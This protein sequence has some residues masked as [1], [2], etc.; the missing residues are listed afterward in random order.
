MKQIQNMGVIELSSGVDAVYASSRANASTDFYKGLLEIKTALQNEILDV[1]QFNLGESSFHVGPT[2][3]GKYP[4]Y[5]ESK[6]GRI[7]FTQSAHLPGVRLQ[8]RSEFLHSVGPDKALSWFSRILNDADVLTDWKLSRLDLYV[9]I[10]GWTPQLQDFE[11]FITRA[12]AKTMYKDQGVITGFGFGKRGSTMNARLYNKTEQMKASNKSW[13]ELLWGDTYDKS[14][15]VWR[16][17]FEFPSTLLRNFGIESAN[18]GLAN[19]EGLWAYAVEEWMTHRLPTNDS[20]TS[21]WPV[22]EVWKSIQNAKLRG[23]S[24]PMERIQEVQ[25]ADSKEGL[26]AAVVGYITS[27]ASFTSA[28]TLEEALREVKLGIEQ[29]FRRTGQNFPELLNLKR[30]KKFL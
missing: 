30:Q 28:S 16:M 1:A 23:E 15:D 21:R 11:L 18:E 10:Q 25:S 24:V 8:I 3:W 19:V 12:N 14:K 6:E 26:I 7:G 9:D 4:I 27:Y 5:L 20:N 2:A 13:T 17:E 22:S 29:K